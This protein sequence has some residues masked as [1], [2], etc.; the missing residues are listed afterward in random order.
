MPAQPSKQHTKFVYDRIFSLLP[1]SQRNE[2]LIIFR[3]RHRGKTGVNKVA[4]ISGVVNLAAEIRYPDAE[5]IHFTNKLVSGTIHLLIGSNT[6]EAFDGVALN[7]DR[8][9][10]S[11]EQA[12]NY[13]LRTVSRL[14]KNPKI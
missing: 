7:L 3:S 5:E 8:N 9:A 14:R 11:N 2:L 6:P 10:V 12:Q 4:Q 1:S 13:E